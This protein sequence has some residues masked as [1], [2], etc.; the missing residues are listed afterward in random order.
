MSEPTTPSIKPSDIATVLQESQQ[1]I[2]S[3]VATITAT[4]TTQSVLEENIRLTD[5]K[6]SAHNTDPESH[7]DIRIALED[8]P[9]V[10]EDPVI[11]GSNSVETGTEATWS[12]YASPSPLYASLWVDK[13][14]VFDKK[15]A[16]I[17]ELS[18]VDPDTPDNHTNTATFTH[19]FT[20][21]RN[22]KTYFQV[23]AVA[24][25]ATYKSARAQQDFTITQHLPPDCS[26]M[27]CTL[28]RNISEGKVYTFRIANIIDLDGDLESVTISCADGHL[29]FSETTIQLNTDYTLTVEEGYNGP[30]DIPIVFTAHDAWGYE[31]SK[32]VTVHLNALPVVTGFAHTLVT[33][34]NPNTN[35]TFRMSGAT[36]PDGSPEKLTIS[37]TCDHPAVTF[38]K[39][40][41][42][43][44]NEDVQI[45]F[46]EIAAATPISIT[47]TVIDPDGGTA[48][49]A[50][51]TATINTPPDTSAFVCTQAALHRPGDTDTISFKGATDANGEAVVYEITNTNPVLTFSKT[52]NIAA[53]EVVNVTFDSSAVHGETYNIT[54]TAIDASNGRTPVTVGIKVNSLPVVTG[55]TT[56]LPSRLAP[57]QTY[58]GSFSGATD[59]D[60]QNL[61]YTI[62]CAD[63]NVVLANN[64]DI[65]AG[66][67]IS[68]TA[69]TAEQLARGSVISLLVTVSDGMETATTTI[70]LYQ[71]ELPIAAGVTHSVADSLT[72]GTYTIGFAGGSD[73]S[74]TGIAYYNIS[75][76]T[77]GISFNQTDDIPT[78][79]TV[80]MTLPKVA[81]PTPAS[82]VITVTDV[83]GERSA[84][85]VTVN[86][87]IAPI[88]RTMTPTITSPVNNAELE[89][90]DDILVSWN[91]IALGVELESGVELA[92]DDAVL[93]TV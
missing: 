13:F 10:I 54:V 89:Y 68:I 30:F 90:E 82:F 38:P 11:T 31:S 23:Q 69:P 56:T 2:D 20:G 41:G 59:A 92:P 55:V 75:S 60:G 14:L 9:P 18:T 47:A 7:E 70:N 62:T 26:Q 42:I 43:K 57:G 1:I 63:P 16:Q 39:A 33:Y 28:P 29:T 46:G 32:S 45:Q 91:A 17:A 5:E 85:S 84:D 25:M 61:T 21:E 67:N 44:L 76:P 64:I 24:N 22:E 48:I 36:D 88:Y 77:G 51:I 19:T 52:T 87:T 4:R 12:L 49:A 83:T 80:Q 66:A 78:A 93:P 71:N 37:L 6:V 81:S 73:P 65:A 79:S 72:G 3:A 74:G 15:G 8:M 53:E 40:E 58:T 86:F 34:P 50:A 27:S 35:Y